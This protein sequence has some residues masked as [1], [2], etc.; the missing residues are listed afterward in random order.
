MQAQDTALNHPLFLYNGYVK[1]LQTNTFDQYFKHNQAGNIVHSRL[2]TKWNF[3]QNLKSGLELRTRL[4]LNNEI[5]HIPNYSAMLRNQEEW[6]NLSVYAPLKDNVVFYANIERAWIEY[7]LPKW[8]VRLGRQ[9]INWGIANTWNPNDLFNTYNFFEV[10]YEERSGA[11]AVKAQYILNDF[12][13]LEIAYSNASSKNKAVAAARYFFN[14]AG[15]DFQLIT[16][17]Y[18]TTFTSG[19]GWAGNIGNIGFKGETQVYLQHKK[20]SDLMAMIECTKIL[21]NNWLLSSAVLFNKE[22]NNTVVDDWHQFNF[23]IAPNRLMPNK[24]NFTIQVSKE[25]TPLLSGNLIMVYAPKVNLLI[26]FPSL[27]YNIRTNLDLDLIY[28]S[29]FLE[30]MNKFQVQS[31]GVYIRLKWSF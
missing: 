11:D 29:F 7:H 12:D 19:I 13:H 16:G 6:M 23:N 20:I 18:H 25:F 1:N 24:W 8:N 3:N 22:G 10:D 28:Q 9:R 21:K 27:K 26:L 15:F 17:M 2:N 5:K 30:S 4:I 14:T 31:H